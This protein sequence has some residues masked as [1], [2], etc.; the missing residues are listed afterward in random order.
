MPYKEIVKSGTVKTRFWICVDLW[1][2]R[3]EYTQKKDL[4]RRQ[5]EGRRVGLG[6][7]ILGALAFM[8]QSYAVQRNCN[9]WD[10]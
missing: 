9:I 5:G 3:D 10:C 7:R 2:C 6:D 8:P 4:F 1:V